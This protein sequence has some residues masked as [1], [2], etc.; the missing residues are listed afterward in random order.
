MVFIKQAFRITG[1]ITGTVI[2][3]PVK[4]I[5]KQI[6]SKF[7]ENIG[8]TVKSSSINTEILLVVSAEGT[9][10]T[11]SGLAKKR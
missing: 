3:T 4:L 1:Q 6:G 10:N 7:I 2:G 5:E 9:W 8:K 11:V